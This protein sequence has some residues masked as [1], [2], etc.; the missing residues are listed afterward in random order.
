MSHIATIKTAITDLEAVKRACKELGFTFKENQK[1]CAFWPTGS[2]PQQCACDH[3]IEL[4][5]GNYKMELG[6]VKTDTGYDLVGDELMKLSEKD[7][8]GPFWCKHIFGM[9]KNPLGQN[10]GRFIQHYGLHKTQIEAAK[11]GWLTTRKVVPGTDKI[12]VHI[13]GM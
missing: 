13:T 6:L 4:P 5:S 7:K 8:R 10:F 9:D 11:K 1:T 3:A 12:Q 2:K